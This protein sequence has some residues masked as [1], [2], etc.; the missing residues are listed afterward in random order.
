MPGLPSLPSAARRVAVWLIFALGAVAAAAGIARIIPRTGGILVQVSGRAAIP[1]KHVQIFLDGAR[2]ECARL[3]CALGG[4]ATGSHELAVHAEYFAP[5]PPQRIEVRA[6]EQAL[7]SFVLDPMPSLGLKVAGNQPNVVLTI[8]G[9]QFGALPQEVQGLA[10]G[11]HQISV[12]GGEAYQ[13]LV[14]SVELEPGKLTDLGVVQL[15]VLIGQLTILPGPLAADRVRL[16]HGSEG[17]D[18][19][20]LPTTR[21]VSADAQWAISASK[22][23]FLDY[24]QEV[25]FEDGV[26]EKTYTVTFERPYEFR[27]LPLS[28]GLSPRLLDADQI[29]V[30]VARYAPSVRRACWRPAFATRDANAAAVARVQVA[31]TIASNGSVQSAITRGDPPGYR[32]LSDCISRRVKG[33]QFPS[34]HA[35][36]TVN[37]PFVYESE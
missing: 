21:T 12:T 37:V 19:H 1:V 4:R 34:A 6:R 9:R 15:K 17:H 35:L 8:D 28:P 33:W 36:T 24:R 23:G 14:R 25:H 2:V 18:L 27:I 22:K 11:S 20:E 13:T 29:R 26:R 5:A 3:P 31:I 16:V 10:I 32:G 7:V 30:T